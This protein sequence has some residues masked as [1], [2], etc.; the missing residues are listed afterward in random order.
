MY[1]INIVSRLWFIA[2]MTSPHLETSH[3]VE[4][5]PCD[6]RMDQS[7]DGLHLDCSNRNLEALPRHLGNQCVVSIDLSRNIFKTLERFDFRGLSSIR[8]LNISACNIEKVS[9]SAFQD[10]V[11]LEE[12]DMKN[13]P[14]VGS[15]LPNGLFTP[16]PKLRRLFVSAPD[17]STSDMIHWE[18][19]SN[20][21]EIILTPRSNNSF[22]H[23]ACS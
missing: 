15:G 23:V 11:L 19:L 3:S 6:M 7:L 2:I 1:Q 21:T 12:L 18:E 8:K 16:L 22:K 14:V 5:V 10:L 17:T 13:N 20:L 9:S 4:L